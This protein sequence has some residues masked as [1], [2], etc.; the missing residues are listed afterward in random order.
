MTRR[1]KNKQQQGSQQK[2]SQQQQDVSGDQEDGK[3]ANSSLADQD[4]DSSATILQSEDEETP[5]ARQ[6]SGE[7]EGSTSTAWEENKKMKKKT[8]EDSTINHLREGS[9]ASQVIREEDSR[10]TPTP[11]QP[12]PS[13]GNTARTRQESFP[14]LQQ[15]TEKAEKS[16]GEEAPVKNIL[17]RMAKTDKTFMRSLS[18]ILAYCQD[19]KEVETHVDTLL[20]KYTAVKEMCLQATHEAERLR[21]HVIGLQEGMKTT[22]QTDKSYA[23]ALA[24]ERAGKLEVPTEK[25]EGQKEQSRTAAVIVTSNTLRADGITSLIQKNIDP[26]DLGLKDVTMRRGK[27]GIVITSTSKEALQKLEE[28]IQKREETRKLLEVKAPKEKLPEVKVVGIQENITEEDIP[29]KI[30]RQNHLQCEESDF[31]VK[32]TWI[33]KQGKTAIIALKIPAYEALQ[34]RTHVNIGWTRCPLYD[35][36]YIPR[37][38]RCANYG[39]TE[40]RCGAEAVRCCNCGRNH[41]YKQ[42]GT[43]V[44]YCWICGE[45][46][47]G[48]SGESC[49]HSMMSDRCPTY[50]RCK[51]EELDKILARLA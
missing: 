20:N 12:L 16:T 41:H 29:G 14:P 37:C 43:S 26:C 36:T 19:N 48:G 1:I 44:H 49:G 21:G 40:T 8:V 23:G 15:E 50:Q 18:A 11:N 13:L 32:T 22:P 24:Q 47:Y 17:S 42:C 30:L 2:S 5:L 34:G 33:G 51:A 6:R 31:L 4:L 25:K 27:Q 35:N 38:R 3:S 10:E 46:E 9:T 39:H 7:K 28:V 45:G